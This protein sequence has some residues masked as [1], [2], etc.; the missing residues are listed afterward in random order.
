VREVILSIRC[1]VMPAVGTAAPTQ[2]LL[3]SPSPA[4]T[5]FRNS[6]AIATAC[7][8]KQNGLAR[9][10]ESDTT[11]VATARVYLRHCGN[12]SDPDSVTWHVGEG[13]T[14]M[15]KARGADITP[16]ETCAKPTS[17]GAPATFSRFCS[18]IQ[19]GRPVP[20]T[21]CYDP[22]A[23]RSAQIAKG[24]A[25]D[26]LTVAGIGHAVSG[27]KHYIIARD[28][29]RSASGMAKAY[30][31]PPSQI[32]LGRTGVWRRPGT[33]VC[34]WEGGYT[35]SVLTVVPKPGGRRGGH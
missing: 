22:R 16:T 29:L 12:C 15:M 27:G 34:R 11:L 28:G 6:H 31:A 32:G 4:I 35:N 7:L 3:Q 19:S 24:R 14:N 2:E 8:V 1:F 18:A 21:L 26:C 23:A 13:S 5:L 33:R 30:T 17:S 20:V 9:R 10:S 25:R